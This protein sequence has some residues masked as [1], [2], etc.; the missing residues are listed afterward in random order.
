M[1]RI[2]DFSSLSQ[3]SIKTL[4]YYDEQGL[5]PP[6]SVDG[7]TGYRYYAVAQLPRLHRIL[8]LRDLGFSLDQIASILNDGIGAEQLRGMLLLRQAE[9]QARVE[10]EQARL[11]RL[12]AQLSLIEKE[13]DMTNEV[14]IKQVPAQ[15]IGSVRETIPNYPAVGRLYGEVAEAL[16][17][18]SFG[19]SLAI[20]HDRE[21]RDKDVDAEAGFLLKEPITASGRVRVHELPPATVAST[22]HHG[23][24]NRL[25]EAYDAL[26]RWLGTSGYSVVAPVRELYLQMSRPVRMDDESYITEI[27]LPVAKA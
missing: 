23:A 15:W 8:A 26:L 11:A 25:S 17:P 16:P 10:E 5:L 14:V 18:G 9:Q 13:Q 24:Y 21:H 7:V 22:L 19:I 12:Q 27:Q 1:L 3:V 6:A 20:W 2:G 4:R